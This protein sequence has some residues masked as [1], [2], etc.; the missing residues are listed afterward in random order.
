M[1]SSTNSG[2]NI[3]WCVIVLYEYLWHFEGNIQSEVWYDVTLISHMVLSHGKI[4]QNSDFA[5]QKPL[6][7]G[8]CA[9][10][11]LP[12]L[13]RHCWSTW[14]LWKVPSGKHTKSYWKWPFI[15]DLPIKIWWFS[16]VTLVYQRVTMK[17]WDYND[18]LV[19]SQWCS[20][21]FLK[22]L[23]HIWKHP[24]HEPNDRMELYWDTHDKLS[25]NWW[26]RNHPQH[27]WSLQS[28]IT[29]LTGAISNLPTVVTGIDHGRSSVSY[30]FVW[31]SVTVKYQHSWP[32]A[33][34]QLSSPW[35]GSMSGITTLT[36]SLVMQNKCQVSSHFRRHFQ[37]PAAA[38][39]KH[40]F[41]F[42]CDWK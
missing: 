40:F 27:H 41:R 24:K 12:E 42:G 32:M 33:N 25:T 23:W 11:G 37:T 5:A 15:V 7:S 2:T 35:S 14:K 4:L 17:H 8:L 21:K 19:I 10:A 28:G 16:I 3:L 26:F 6:L 18:T 38:V 20:S 29:N 36:T 31:N 1:L 39:V 9:K 22:D 13:V 30:S 34:I